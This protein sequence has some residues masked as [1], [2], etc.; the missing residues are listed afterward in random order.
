[1][2]NDNDYPH[3]LYKNGE[4][5][6]DYMIVADPGEEAAAEKDGYAR[7]NAAPAKKRKGA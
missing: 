5:G 4:P 6:D 7:A 1:M 2:S 3:M